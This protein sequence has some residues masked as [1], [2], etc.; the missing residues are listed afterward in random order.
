[1]KLRLVTADARDIRSEV[2]FV[3][4]FTGLIG[5]AEKA[6][7]DSLGGALR[8]VLFAM[9]SNRFLISRTVQ[10][11]RGNI[12]GSANL[13]LLNLGEIEKFTL[14]DLKGAVSHA[15]EETLRHRFKVVATPVIGISDHVGL[16]IE[17]AY[18]TVLT[19]V[20]ETL[21][22]YEQTRYAELSI[23]DLIIFDNSAQKVSFFKKITSEI[24]SDLGVKFRH[25]SDGQYEIYFEPLD[26]EVER[27][28]VDISD[29]IPVGRWRVIDSAQGGK[30]EQAYTIKV[31]FLAANPRDTRPLRL[32]EEI[33]EIDS[34]LRHAKFSDR[35]DI[36]QHWAVRVMDLQRYLLR[37]QP[38]IV[39]FSG[40]GSRNGGIIL[41]DVQGNSH[42]V[43][44]RSLSRLFAVLK[45]NIRCVV[46]NA[47][48]TEEQAEAIAKHIDCVVGMSSAVGDEA[49]IAFAAAFY[50]ALGYGRDIKTAFELGCV[51]IDLENLPEPDVPKLLAKQ[52]D[53][54]KLYFV[55][56]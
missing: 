23:R 44:P 21:T 51:Q 38:D 25:L 16:P 15:I 34:A 49:A 42:L 39:H 53:P 50:H 4:H 54:S 19:A 14:G 10:V 22:R 9:D 13:L 8:G 17:R 2:Q 52:V 32:D 31:L 11:P 3:K 56:L 46:L 18:R 24:L 48:Y 45:D 26:R 7:D 36:R 29:Q 43:S 1:M 30:L 55:S 35:F 47:C 12:I 27:T 33:R 28:T 41:E 5:G 40:H 37:H 20:V 6:L